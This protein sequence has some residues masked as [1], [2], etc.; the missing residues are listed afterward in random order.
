MRKENENLSESERRRRK[1]YKRNR[2]KWII[3]QTAAAALFV[4]LASIFFITY[5]RIADTYEIPYAENG[6][7]NYEVEL[8]PNDS[9]DEDSI[10]EGYSYVTA[11]IDNIV[12]DFSYTASADSESAKYEYAYS[13]VATVEVIDNS[14]GKQLLVKPFVLKSAESAEAVAGTR[15]AINEKVDID[16]QKYND[17][18]KSFVTTWGIGNVTSRLTVQMTTD[19]TITEEALDCRGSTRYVSEM[20][21]P[22]TQKTVNIEIRKT[23]PGAA[24][25]LVSENA[26]SAKNGFLTASLSSGGVALLIIALLI[27]FI[28]ITR[29]HDINY[30]I[31]VKR[32]LN[33]YR[34][35]IQIISNEFDTEGYQL[36]CVDS[37][38]DMLSIRDTLQ[39]PILMNENEDE[40]RTVFIIPTATRMLYLYEIK[41]DNYDEI[42]G[43]AGEDGTPDGGEPFEKAA[44]VVI[45]LDYDGEADTAHEQPD[46]EV[47]EAAPVLEKYV[48]PQISIEIIEEPE[49][50]PAE[51]IAE[52]PAEVIVEEP[53]EVIAEEPAEVIVEEPAEAIA[54]EPA[55]AIVEEPAEAIAEEP[56][57]EIVEEPAEEIVEEPAEEIVEEPVEEIVEEPVEATVE[58]PVEAIAE[59]PIKEPVEEPV[60]TTAETAPDTTVVA[61]R[62][63]TSFTSRLI[64]AAD[65]VKERYSL[66]K[67][68]LLSFEGMKAKTSLNFETYKKGGT[69]CAR[70]D[71]KGTYV[72]LYLALDPDDYDAEKYRFRSVKDRVK[73]A[74]TPM[75]IKIKSDLTV[76]LARELIDE[77]MKKL[78]I[79]Q[80]DV[81]NVNY[82]PPYETTEELIRR[83]L[84]KVLLPAG[85]KLPAGAHTERL[86]VSQLLRD[87]RAEADTDGQPTESYADEARETAEEAK[88]LAEVAEETLK[89]TQHTAEV[90]R[91]MV[92]AV[93]EDATPEPEIEEAIPEPLTVEEVTEPVAEE[94]IPE[95]VNTT[96]DYDVK[97]LTDDVSKDDLNEAIVAPTPI[98][99]EISYVEPVPEEAETEPETGV[100][101]IGVVW[102]ER[103][104]KNKVYKYD[105]NGET[106]SEGD[107]VLVPTRD[108]ARQKD[109]IR[110]AAVARGNYKLESEKLT[111]PLKKIIGVVR[112]KI[113]SAL[114]AD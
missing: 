48:E 86:D 71:V 3:I 92:E 63:R 9:Y 53:A 67:N 52:E 25:L 74:N 82:C 56:A 15:V 94:P 35:Y 75:L 40:T 12:A 69:N 5:L 60:E 36:L 34:S 78:G 108:I 58:E 100:E 33:A 83:D 24:K 50:V 66:I 88:Q 102:P 46:V 30:S 10:G 62:Y 38:T 109:V 23:A 76:R 93:G 68:Y 4:L 84:I 101:V 32:I 7:I 43:G 103:K 51:E 26:S 87:A 2:N 45:S 47:A 104:S 1:N 81:G 49:D 61:L 37:F 6:N 99:E 107:V 90:V 114:S 42:Y 57:E 73:V 77:C 54:E 98:L 89:E 110:K 39:S 64:Q 112:R 106:L 14:T 65:N 16:F 97:I 17:I 85:T 59:E 44:P 19:V 55:E 29:N 31:K 27:V 79:P 20:V 11:L 18:A 91:E 21:M 70:L 105:P 80:G 8:L 113:E 111:H 72:H 22:L 13:V 96:E 41:V 28:F 95:P